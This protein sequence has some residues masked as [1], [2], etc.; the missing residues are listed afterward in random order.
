MRGFTI[1]KTAYIFEFDTPIY[2]TYVG[3]RDVFLNGAIKNKKRLIV[4]I[5]G[6]NYRCNI[7]P[8][9]WKKSA[10]KFDDYKLKEEPMKMYGNS[11]EKFVKPKEPEITNEDHKRSIEVQ[12]ACMKAAIHK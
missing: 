1:S 2:G 6:T 12:M 11:V 8:R 10:T 7:D 4:K 3:I 5:K 9:A